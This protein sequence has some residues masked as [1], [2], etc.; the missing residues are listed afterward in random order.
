MTSPAVELLNVS[1]NYG[2]D[3]AVNDLNLTLEAK[4]ILALVGPS[5]CGKTTTLR[6]IAGFEQPNEGTIDLA[7]KTVS[8]AYKSRPPE[9]RGI[10]V[11]FQDYA[12]FPH[13]T[14]QE[15]VA[16]GLRNPKDKESKAQVDSI[17]NLVGLDSRRDRFPHELSGGE[18][19]RVALARAL[20]PRPILLLMDEPFSNLD[21]DLRLKMRED[22]RVILKAT[23]TTAIFVTHDQEEALYMG[24]QLA[25]MN[26]GRIEQVGTPE[27]IF[28]RP[29]TRFVAEFMGNTD[30]LPGHVV[31]KGLQTEIGLLNQPVDQPEG[32]EV[33]I[34]L[35]AD[36]VIFE[37]K[38]GSKSLILARHFRGALNLYR[39]RLP[40]GRLLHAYKS[41]NDIYNPGTPVNVSLEPG[42]KLACFL[43]GKLLN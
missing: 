2:S 36:D 10:G 17:L 43:D 11:V 19:Q 40:S 15:N 37:P 20:V 16:F 24:D 12:L 29:S 38:A 8:T 3:Q 33:E 26:K 6:L 31:P 34:A 27:D 4:K 1:K 21:A 7:G 5:G 9:E 25:V 23:H 18:R 13:L 22:V 14:A 35:R 32:T 28:H 39:L 42:H 41:H 30:F